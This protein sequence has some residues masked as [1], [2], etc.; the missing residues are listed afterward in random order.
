MASEQRLP[1]LATMEMVPPGSRCCP[2]EVTP[3]S[4]H[5]YLT[6]E[7]TVPPDKKQKNNKL[8]KNKICGV[9]DMD[10]AVFV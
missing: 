4:A 1:H 6:I 9:S 8:N 5:P 3:G 2:L 7:R 10:L